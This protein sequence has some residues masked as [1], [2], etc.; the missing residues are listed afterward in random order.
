MLFR[1]PV[2]QEINKSNIT[3]MKKEVEDALTAL[4]A[5]IEARLV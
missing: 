5:K 4:G 1:S 3:V 2:S